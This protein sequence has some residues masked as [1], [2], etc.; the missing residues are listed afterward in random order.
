METD[1]RELKYAVGLV[2]FHCRK[3]EF[4]IQEL[5]AHLILYNFCEIITAH[6]TVQKK[7]QN[8]YTS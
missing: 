4:V 1:F 6:V 2:N 3:A 7:E 8:I 5:W